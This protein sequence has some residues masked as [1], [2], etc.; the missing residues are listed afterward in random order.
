MRQYFTLPDGSQVEIAMNPNLG[1]VAYNCEHKK[2][3][4]RSEDGM[5][6]SKCAYEIMKMMSAFGSTY[7]KKKVK[8]D[9]QENEE[10]IGRK[11]DFKD[12][13]NEK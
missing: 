7:F 9:I 10:A 1:F 3:V 8:K 11:L 6:C 4:N 2:L 12:G 13:K 5:V